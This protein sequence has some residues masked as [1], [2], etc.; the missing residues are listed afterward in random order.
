ME[1]PTEDNST[2][3]Y[4]LTLITRPASFEFTMPML[5]TPCKGRNNEI[6]LLI[7]NNKY[8]VLVFI[9]VKP[10]HGTLPEQSTLNIPGYNMF[11]SDLDQPNSRGVVIYIKEQIQAKILQPT[12]GTIFYDAIWTSIKGAENATLLLGCIYRSGIFATAITRDI[13]LHEAILW[14]ANHCGF[15]HKLLVDVF[16]HPI[17]EWMSS[18]YLPNNI[19]SG[20]P[21]NTFVD[22]IRD[23]FLNFILAS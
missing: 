9:E 17:I 12:T 21:T 3:H 6:T 5:I 10:K 1:L 14:L 22:C 8:D 13:A 16:N 11:T 7:A 4:A 20:S 15:L 18:S 23:C 19:P 2:Q